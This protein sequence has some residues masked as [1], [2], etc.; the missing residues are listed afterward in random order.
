MTRVIPAVA[1]LI[2]VMLLPTAEASILDSNDTTLVSYP[3]ADSNNITTD[4]ATGLDWLDI[5]TTTNV[6]YDDMVN[7]LGVGELADF[8]YATQPEVVLFF[9]HLGLPA[10]S[11]FSDVTSPDPGGSLFNVAS[12]FTGLTVP[13]STVPYAFGYTGTESG[14]GMT[15]VSWYQSKSAGEAVRVAHAYIWDQDDAR[16][17]AG[18]W[19]VRTSTGGAVPEPS[20]LAIWSLLALCGIGYG[21]RRRKA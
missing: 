3:S 21:W 14:F 13:V 1:F 9:D 5:D 17:D 8:R 11:M 6:S 19:L 4:T 7:L 15:R 10:A 12:S 2:T 16:T 18:S 20:T